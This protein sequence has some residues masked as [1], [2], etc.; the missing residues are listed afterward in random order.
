MKPA[1]ATQLL[2]TAGLAV[3]TAT[4][5]FPV[6]PHGANPAAAAPSTSV[7]SEQA[8]PGGPAGVA[9]AATSV[10]DASA[11]VASSSGMGEPTAAAPSG[12][13]STSP[14]GTAGSPS[15]VAIAPTSQ[16]SEASG[17]GRSDAEINGW[18][19]DYFEGF[20]GSFEDTKWG[21]YGWKDPEVG[22]GAMGVM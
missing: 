5:C 8:S 6:Q 16:P 10:S 9:A 14:H 12:E 20:D 7:G 18:S 2:M 17:L 15:D 19:V 22:H 21:H 1:R 3:A 13:P 11:P 4:A